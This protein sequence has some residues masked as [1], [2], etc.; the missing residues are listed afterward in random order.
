LNLVGGGGRRRV[1]VAVVLLT[2]L[3]AGGASSAILVRTITL[4]PGQCRRV[5]IRTR[6]CAARARTVTR[7]VTVAPSSIGK[8]FSGNGSQTLQPL[9]IPRAVYVHWTAQL[10]AYGFNM[11]HVSG[12]CSNPF[13]YVFFDNGNNA[14]SGSSYVPA[15]TCTFQVTASGPWTLSF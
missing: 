3:A 5:N 9:Q 15:G 4:R 10:D 12:D 8:S 2:L 11:F 13:N 1:L 14:T 6:V 7:T